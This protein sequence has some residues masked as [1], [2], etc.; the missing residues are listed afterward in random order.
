MAMINYRHWLRVHQSNW[1]LCRKANRI[2][3]NVS[4]SSDSHEAPLL[5]FLSLFAFSPTRLLHWMHKDEITL[6]I[7]LKN[8][9]RMNSKSNGICLLA[10][11]G[12]ILFPTKCSTSSSICTSYQ[13]NAWTLI[14]VQ[15]EMG[16]HYESVCRVR[17][18]HK[19]SLRLIMHRVIQSRLL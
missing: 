11:I 9:A 19:N 1:Q 18:K 6:V 13:N 17:F 8:I 16:I 7:S 4:A 3:Y 12:I 15:L 14:V 5:A 10:C 2:F